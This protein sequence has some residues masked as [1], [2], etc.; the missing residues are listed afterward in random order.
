MW[1]QA[2]QSQ[3]EMNKIKSIVFRTYNLDS[4]VGAISINWDL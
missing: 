3:K 4:T 2:I 1:T